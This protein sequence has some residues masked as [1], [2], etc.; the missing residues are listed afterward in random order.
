MYLLYADGSGD[1]KMK[2]DRTNNGLYVLSGVI[3]HES[4]LQTVENDIVALKRRAL[5]RMDPRDWE[6]HAHEICNNNGFFKADMGLDASKKMEIFQQVSN[7]VC[8]SDVTLLI[9][10]V[11]KDRIRSRCLASKPTENAWTFVAERFDHFLKRMPE[12]T[13][14]GMIF[15]DSSDKTSESEI[16]N[17][18]KR[19]IR[20]GTPRRQ[21]EHI[22]Q[23]PA[24]VRSDEHLTVQLAD[25]AAYIAN[26]HYK[27]DSRFDGWLD[28]H[29]K[30]I[31][32]PWAGARLR[33]QRVSIV[34]VGGQFRTDAER[35][36]P[37]NRAIS[38]LM[39]V[40][41]P[42]RYIALTREGAI[43]R[44]PRIGRGRAENARPA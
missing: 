10:V 31:P 3:V 29:G 14:R 19:I 2:R 37:H 33:N 34:G 40:V 12:E 4:R 5:P 21:I 6:L 44:G 17:T 36:P 9:V 35:L 38:R 32:S 15:T 27:G 28:D 13:N 18:I 11:F 23:G 43:F 20:N 7:V 42:R 22:M 30:S 8:R 1:T 25:M 26:R 24:F 39:L 16:S 41:W